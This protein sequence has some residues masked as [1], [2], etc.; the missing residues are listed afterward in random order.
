MRKSE[1]IHDDLP[2]VMENFRK[3]RTVHPRP[4]QSLPTSLW[5]L[6]SPLGHPQHISQSCAHV[7]H[8]LTP[9]LCVLLDFHALVSFLTFSCSL[10]PPCFVQKNET[11]PISQM[12]HPITS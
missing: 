10:A 11:H 12:Y 3:L 2:V 1:E 6:F 9:L 4:L 5:M 7:L 8:L